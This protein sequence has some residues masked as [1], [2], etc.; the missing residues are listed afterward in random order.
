[1][2]RD[3]AAHPVSVVFFALGIVLGIGMFFS[4]ISV[5]PVVRHALVAESAPVAT[6]GTI[7]TTQL[8]REIEGAPVHATRM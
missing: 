6:Q 3:K 8:Y 2:Y 5:A 4:I 7:N 1:M